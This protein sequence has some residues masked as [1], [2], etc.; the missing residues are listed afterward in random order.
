VGGYEGCKLDLNGLHEQCACG[1]RNCTT[2]MKSKSAV[3]SLI[4]AE[5][6][7]VGIC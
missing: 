4:D 3:Q 2:G 6:K 5:R 7:W 1:R